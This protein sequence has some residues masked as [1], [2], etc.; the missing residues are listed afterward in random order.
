MGFLNSIRDSHDRLATGESLL[1]WLEQVQLVPSGVL[2]T[3]R[4]GISS[5]E[6]NEIAAQARGLREWF[7]AF[8]R[9]H[10]GRTLGDEDLEALAPLNTL[11]ERDEVFCQLVEA[12]SQITGL[13]L[14]VQR[15]WDSPE[16][17]LIAIAQV[18]AAFICATD[19]ACTELVAEPASNYTFGY[20]RAG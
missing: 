6:L 17:L 2:A 13:G 19:F 4:S 12:D 3:W 5:R 8:M 10:R 11:L 16:S 1:L 18:L 15:R 20:M 14:R 7:R 9:V